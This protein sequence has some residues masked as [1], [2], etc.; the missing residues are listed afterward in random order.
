MI[1][2]KWC[3]CDM[4]GTLLNSEGL[5]SKENEIALKRLQGM[6]VEVIIASGRIDLMVKSFIKQLDLTGP[7]ISCNGGLIRN[8]KTGEVIYSKLMDKHTT[9]EILN[10]CINNNVDFLI[11]TAEMVYSNKNNPKAKTYE[12]LNKSLSQDLQIPI[13]YLDSGIIEEIDVIDVLKILL[14]CEKHE[15]VISLEK[16]FSKYDTLTVV[17]S[18]KGLLDIMAADISKGNALKTLSEKLKVDLDDVIV[19][20]DNYNDMDMFKCAGMPIAMGNSVEDIKLQAKYI[21]KSNN[22]AGIAFAINNYILIS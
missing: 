20:G 18:A 7:I 10:Y 12:V 8:I 19:F 13:T 14:V 4:D 1:K 11:Y 3:V 16:H 21:T 6:G 17:S 5:I 22:E 9:K 2:Y 15:E